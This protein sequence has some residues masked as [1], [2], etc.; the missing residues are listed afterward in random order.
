MPFCIIPNLTLKYERLLQICITNQKTAENLLRHIKTVHL[1]SS[2]DA[3]RIEREIFICNECSKIYFNKQM[4]VVHMAVRHR[5][6]RSRKERI[7]CPK[8]M[9]LVRCNTLWSHCQFEDILS[10]ACCPIC[11]TKFSNMEEMR[12]HI[13]THPNYFYCNICAYST[14]S[15][16][17]F[18][19]HVSKY[20][21]RFKHVENVSKAKLQEC[22]I[23]SIRYMQWRLLRISSFKGLNL[24]PNIHICILC[25]EICRN[26]DE[27]KRHYL[28]HIMHVE[29]RVEKKKHACICGE[30]FFNSVL[31]KHHV[32]KMQGEHRAL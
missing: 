25:R 14:K 5:N 11:L 32:F 21:N 20:K 29:Q 30:E 10:I 1:L 28:S 22:F 7:E 13:S 18:K 26:S 12:S 17:N 31:L 23:S 8:C 4:L 15:D 9:K 19:E 6:V 16:K 27:M 3:S 2:E 24:P